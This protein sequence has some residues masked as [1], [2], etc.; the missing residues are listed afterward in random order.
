MNYIRRL[1]WFAIVLL[2]APRL[3]AAEEAP[4]MALSGFVEAGIGHAELTNGNGQWN[5]Y[6]ARAHVDVNQTLKLAGE[7]SS[8]EH[9]G[10]R[11][12]YLA[13]GFTHVFDDRWH[14]TVAAGTSDGGFFLPR[15]RTDGFLYYKWFERKKLV[16]SVGLSY[17]RAKDEHSDQALTLG[18]AYYF[19]VPWIAEAGARLNK[20]YPG[21]V[22]ADRGFAAITWGQAKKTYVTLRYEAGREAYQLVGS[23]STLSDF[24]SREWSAVW[25]QWL[26]KGIGFNLRAAHYENPTYRRSGLEFGLFLDF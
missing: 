26:G 10:D 14:A 18:G 16:T 7:I 3:A 13:G 11:G 5:D 17:Y 1:S 15:L 24:S 9:F 22:R 8:Q 19:D 25:R 4:M 21:G 2:G 20:S 12:T 23:G 6:Y